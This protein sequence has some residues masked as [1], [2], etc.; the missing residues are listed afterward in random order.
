MYF[1][2]IIYSI[3]FDKY[4][5]GQT[6]NFHERIKRHNAGYEKATLPYLPWISKCILNKE[7]RSEAILLEKS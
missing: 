4:Y 5:I 6:Q 3:K 7:T 1:V 2:Y